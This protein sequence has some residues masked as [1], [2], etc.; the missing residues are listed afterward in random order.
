MIAFADVSEATR[1]AADRVG[2]S[3]T[4]PATR[5]E[6]PLAGGASGIEAGSLPGVAC[7]RNPLPVAEDRMGVAD[8]AEA[9]PRPATNLPSDT[10]RLGDEIARLAAHLHA[11]TLRLLV[12]IR[13]FDERE[14]WVQGFRSCAEWLS[15]RTGI[16]A[17]PAREKVRVARALAP[18]PRI[19]GAMARGEL[20]YSKVRALTRVATAENEEELLEVARHATAAHIEKL[21]RAWRRMDRLEE[22]EAERERHRRRYLRLYPDEDGSYV[23]RGRLDA[24]VGSLLE[25]ALEWAREALYRREAGDLDDLDDPA[26]PNGH[27]F[28]LSVSGEVS[29][30]GFETEESPELTATVPQRL[31]DALGLL[32]ERAMGGGEPGSEVSGEGRA[33]SP[34]AG[35]A[36]RFQVVVHVDLDTLK[37]DSELGSAALEGSSVHV[38]A[39]TSMRLACDSGVVEMTHGDGGHVLDVGRKRR[40]VPPAIRRALE[41]RDRGCRF[42]GCTCRFTDAHHIVHWANGGETKLENL[43][44]LCRRHHRAVHEGGFRVELVADRGREARERDGKDLGGGLRSAGGAG[45]WE[46]H[47]YRPDGRPIPLVP[48]PP[49]LPAD[50][51]EEL[52]R[53]HRAGGVHPG[54]WTTTPLWDGEPLDCSLA[55]DMLRGPLARARRAE[56]GRR[57]DVPAE[58]RRGV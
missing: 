13:E 12:L 39:E 3:E 37:G 19:S 2:T 57:M 35:R 33:A 40:T 26:H 25:K 5:V 47:F 31:A 56:G 36:D 50:P 29:G 44:L 55:I 18:L 58:T 52:V 15:W 38:P 32:A 24:E 7:I 46:V 54:A 45:G 53:D 16:A 9:A 4:D 34:V 14:G 28:G 10:E 43:L 22:G 1:P 49:F 30:S 23:L 27:P 51:V 21:V 41:Y 6:A 42:P 20:S 48:R 17:G 8:P 11:A